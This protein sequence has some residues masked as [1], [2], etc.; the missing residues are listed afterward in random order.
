MVDANVRRWQPDR[1]LFL[2]VVT[3]V[4]IGLAMVFSSSTVLTLDKDQS[5]FFFFVKQGIATL[6]GIVA[7]L[8]IM[9]FDYKSLGQPK[10]YLSL[11][12][13]ALVLLVVV[14]FMPVINNTNR[15]F[16]IFGFSFQPSEF[17]KIALIITLAAVSSRWKGMLTSWGFIFLTLAMLVA[18][19]I[20]LIAIEPDLGTAVVLTLASFSILFCAGIGMKKLLFL[21]VVATLIISVFIYVSPYRMERVM[22]F[23]NPSED[24]LGSGWQAY[25][26]EIALGSGGVLGSGFMQ[27]KQKLFFLPAAHTDFIYSVVGEEWG[28]IGTTVLLLLFL[29]LFARG[30]RVAF[31]SRDLFGF[32]LAVGFT[33]LV[34]GQAMVNMSVAA[35]LLPTKGIPLPLISYGGSSIIFSLVALGVLLNVSQYCR[36]VN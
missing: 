26:S 11:L 22:T 15:W 13:V 34:V 5:P 27:G 25:Q 24:K 1:S 3:L 14:L 19:V 16:R 8:F 35:T 17:A 7:L 10:V 28:I 6:V 33:T 23:F 36:K 4:A 32:L 18:P 30:L 29:G 2:L 12:G 20:F 21:A 31:T 9:R